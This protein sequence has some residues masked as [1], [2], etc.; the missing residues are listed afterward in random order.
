M[1]KLV[2]LN[3]LSP[4]THAVKLYFVVIIIICSGGSEWKR[5][6]SASNKQILPQ[7]V[8]KFVTPLSEIADELMKQLGKSRDDDGNISDMREFVVKWSFQ[9]T[10]KLWYTCVC[11]VH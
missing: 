6:R 9:G 1:T 3:F 11:K 2:V 10:Y 4:C 8:A 7:R 5:I